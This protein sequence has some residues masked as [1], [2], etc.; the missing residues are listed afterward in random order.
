MKSPLFSVRQRDR[1]LVKRIQ[2]EERFRCELKRKEQAHGAVLRNA[3]LQQEQ[4]SADLDQARQEIDNAGKSLA[5][6][7][8]NSEALALQLKTLHQDFNDSK[9]LERAAQVQ[10]YICNQNWDLGCLVLSVTWLPS[11]VQ[12]QVQ[13]WKER[14]IEEQRKHKQ[15]LDAAAAVAEAQIDA[16]RQGRSQEI[17]D[18]HGK[19]KDVLHRKNTTVQRRALCRSVLALTLGAAAHNETGA[20]CKNRWMR[21]TRVFQCMKT[22]C[23]EKRWK[24]WSR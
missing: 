18:I 4:T 1:C 15:D 16:I 9:N 7:K 22:T 12:T 5:A 3:R 13:E 20:G 8:R 24:S 23:I 6:E 19:L 2:Q 11:L 10:S 17:D 14:L 21:Q